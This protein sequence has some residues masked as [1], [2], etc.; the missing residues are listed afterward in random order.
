[1]VVVFGAIDQ[2]SLT[3]S[4]PWH[5]ARSNGIHQHQFD[6]RFPLSRTIAKR[7][8]P[9][10]G[11]GFAHYSHPVTIFAD[12][13]DAQDI[14]GGPTVD[15]ALITAL[16]TFFASPWIVP[17]LL[18]LAVLGLLFEIKAGSAGIGILI[19]FVSLGL[20][21]GS[22]IVLGQA[23]WT[24]VILLISGMLFMALEVFLIPGFGV[25]GT[26]GA[27][28][29]MAAVVFTLGGMPGAQVTSILSILGA[30]LVIT[31]SVFVAWLRHLPHSTRFAGLLHRTATERS[32]GFISAPI[33]E[34]LVGQTGLAITDLRP[35][36]VMELNG[37]RVDV[38]TEGEFLSAGTSLTV[39]RAEGYRQVVRA[40]HPASSSPV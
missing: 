14:I 6:G 7:S 38:I 16:A 25:T 34:E 9:E 33:R 5:K 15:A 3:H 2:E 17:V 22:A 37:E 24:E 8:G 40:D 18:A 30:S 29:L 1:M 4:N 21:F 20:F 23:G 12:W 28:L 11:L 19:S 10:T 13:A 26:L 31:S 27:L 32:Q 36:G 35:S 39:V